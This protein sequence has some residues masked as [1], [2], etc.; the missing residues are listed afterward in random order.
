M[1][2]MQPLD[3]AGKAQKK[4]NLE[5][6]MSNRYRDEDN[7]PNFKCDECLKECDVIEE[8]FDYSG[9]HCN[10]GQDGTHRAGIY[11]SSCCDS[12]FSEI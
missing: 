3:Q 4:F 6:S 5:V 12:E 10:G 7:L 2:A 9:T 8:T 1:S 11:S